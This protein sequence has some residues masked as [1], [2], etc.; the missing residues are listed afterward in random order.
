MQ[1]KKSFPWQF[2]SSYLKMYPNSS[3]TW[4]AA[5]KFSWHGD[6]QRDWGEEL[7]V[8]KLKVDNANLQLSPQ[9]PAP[10]PQSLAGYETCMSHLVIAWHNVE[11]LL[12]SRA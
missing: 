7:K 1:T 2:S 5:T 3:W 12:D 6:R 11:H 10:N 4:N 8:G 9:S